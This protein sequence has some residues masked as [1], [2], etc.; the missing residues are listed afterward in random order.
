MKPPY[1]TKIHR[2]VPYY[3]VPATKNRDGSPSG[4]GGCTFFNPERDRFYCP[5]DEPGT[6]HKG[7]CEPPTGKLYHS[8][9]IPKNQEAVAAY[10]ARLLS[11]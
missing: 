1:P 8:W 5:H 7:C 4:C 11:T 3:I 6:R 2:G 9:W 10:I